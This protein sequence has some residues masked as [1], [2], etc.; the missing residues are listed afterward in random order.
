VGPFKAARQGLAGKLRALA[1]T[2]IALDETVEGAGGHRFLGRLHSEAPKIPF[3][4]G[5][6]DRDLALRH[7][8]RALELAPEEPDNALFLAT[9]ILEHRPSES[10]EALDLLRRL[11]ERQ[12]RA[13]HRVED[14]HSLAEARRL[15]ATKSRRAG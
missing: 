4:T 7:L 11:A 8:R 3:F 6:V 10:A 1:E 12:P 14:T 2:A 5:W 15:L 9:A 13:D